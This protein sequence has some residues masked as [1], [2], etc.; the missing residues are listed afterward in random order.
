MSKITKPDHPVHNLIAQRWSP[1]YF[2]PRS[3][4]R[5]KLLSCLEAARWAA[6]S[7]NE[8]PWSFIIAHREDEAGFAKMVGCLMEANQAWAQHVGVLMITTVSR[9]F[10]KNG[11]P[12]RVAE[13]DLGLAMGNFC[14]QAT[15]MGLHVHQMAGL[16]IEKTRETYAVPEGHDPVTA[17]AI[18]YAA[19]PGDAPK[20]HP[21]A[22]RDTGERSRK[23][24]SA[25]V[26]T[27]KFGNAAV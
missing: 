12:N 13:H 5:D 11:K 15:E 26:F 19:D 10:T 22:Q 18:G 3:V 7:Y 20:D 23:P 27:G 2:A 8:Q 21:L 6:S 25:F 4:E 14:L 9:T 24:L 1:Y 16:D 17:V